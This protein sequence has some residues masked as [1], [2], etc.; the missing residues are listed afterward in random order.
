[1]KHIPRCVWLSILLTALF[2]VSACHDDSV[3]STP[4][5]C[6]STLFLYFP[7]SSD[8]TQYFIQN[9]SDIESSMKSVNMEGRKVVVFMSSSATQAS[10]FELVGEGSEIKKVTLKNYSN[11]AYTT[12]AGI[13]SILNDVKK[14]APA[15]TYSMIIGCHGMGWLP[16]DNPG[17]DSD[18]LLLLPPDTTQIYTTRY[19]GGESR[20]ERTDISSLSKGI[21]DAGIKMEYILFDDCYMS[22]IE[23]AYELKD[24][25]RYLIGS[26]SELMSYGMPYSMIGKSLLGSPDYQAICEGF[27]SF[28]SNYSPPCGTLA[29]TDCSQLDSMAAVMKKINAACSFDAKMLNSLQQ[30]D[31]YSP[32]VFYDYGDY[33]SHLCKDESL[34]SVFK[35]QLALLVPY[36]VCT[37]YFYSM[38]GGIKPIQAFSGLTTSDP[39]NSAAAGKKAETKW[40]QATH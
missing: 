12:A 30:M 20:E 27:Y 19:F 21:M 34:L 24:A 2:T 9:L 16:V 40:Y 35:K 5:T 37:N 32:S 26:A 15:Q 22:S 4:V 31:G 23:V 6:K 25:T 18:G 14:F 1:M 39:S 29:V 10:L 3:S 11:P 13:T 38:L 7:W 17:W 33:V 8:L 36:K 28:Y